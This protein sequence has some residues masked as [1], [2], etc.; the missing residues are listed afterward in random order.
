MEVKEVTYDIGDG[1]RA[2]KALQREYN[3]RHPVKYIDYWIMGNGERIKISE[4][5]DSHILNAIKKIANYDDW[6]YDPNYD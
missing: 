1:D 6:Q 2:I 3:K 4:M 5:T